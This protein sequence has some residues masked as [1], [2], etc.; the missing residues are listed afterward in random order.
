VEDHADLTGDLE[1]ENFPSL[2]IAD[3]AGI[4]FLGPL[5]PQLGTIT[6]LVEAMQHPAAPIQPHLPETLTIVNRLAGMPEMSLPG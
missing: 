4:R 2:L 1:L 3:Q 5:T 6:R